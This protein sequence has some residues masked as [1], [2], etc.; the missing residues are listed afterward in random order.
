MS[1]LY[2]QIIVDV[3]TMQTNQPYT[4]LVPTDMQPSLSV[5]MRVVVPFGTRKVLGFVIAL[6]TKAPQTVQTLKSIDAMMDLNPILSKEHLALSEYLAQQTFAYR[7]AI[8]QT[9]LPNALKADYQK[10]L[11][12][13][14]DKL[15]PEVRERL[16]GTADNV[17]FNPSDWSTADQA[18][19]A[20]LQRQGKV[21]IDIHVHDKA[22]IKT[23]LAYTLSSD[24]EMLLM[25][26]EALRA[27]AQ[28]Q[29]ALL[30][31]VQAHLGETWTKKELQAQLNLSDA[32]LQQGVQKGWLVK[33]QVEQLR[34]PDMQATAKRVYALNEEQQVAFETIM[35]KSG[36][37]QPFLLSGITGSGKTEV[38]LQVA[39]QVLAQGKNILFLVPEIA[40]TPQMVARV[41]QRF[42]DQIAVLHSGLSEGE[43]YDEWRRI[44]RSAARVVVG[45]RSAV[46]A[47][48]ANIGL[49]IVD[50]EHETTYKQSDNPRYHARD[51][52]LWRGK[53]H[54]APVILGS[55]TPSLESRARAQ[56]GVYTLLRLT[57]R[58]GQA[59]L[60]N[61][62]II[63]M[64]D[65][66]VQGP[67]TDI[68]PQL[69]TQIQSRLN[70]GEQSVLLLNRRGFSS[71]VMCR[72]C[73]FVPR[74]PNCNLAMT[75]H[76]DSHSLKCHY[77][78]HEEAI[79][80]VCASCGS[81]EIRY[82]GTG[83]EKVESELKELFPEAR[84]L[85][86]DQDTTRKKGS[87]AT[88]LAAFGNQEYDILLGTQMIAKGLDFPDVTL[89]GVLNADTGLGLP[90]FHASERTFQ[91]LTQVAG[92]AGRAHK[93][94]EVWIQT[95]N[96]DHYAIQLAQQ[97]DYEQFY[98]YEMRQRHI[99]QYAPYYFTVQIQ[100]SHVEE[101]Q[102]AVQM[103]KAAKWLRERLPN[104]AILLGPTPK[105]I[106]K[107]RNRY[108][109]QMILK[110]KNAQ[111]I[112][113]LLQVLQERAQVIAKK[114]LQLSI[115]RE[116]VNFL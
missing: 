28:K 82:Y 63:D 62:Q 46:F 104:D 41:A 113:P 89:V 74:D 91:L 57:Q 67:E 83:T 51:V 90:D 92:R 13:R 36:Q 8:L 86:L 109:Y 87:M 6:T 43:R 94:G 114:G 11:H 25:A 60:P 76:M 55:A 52:A 4:Y 95:F 116:P 61:V 71:F 72:D 53:H 32:V 40:L 65:V 98:Q 99:G 81:R 103:A 54:Q 9:M 50:E 15:T 97:Q 77:C 22:K 59:A 79:P 49:I 16:F 12:L 93:A 19:I 26:Q 42:G 115:D 112:D 17:P 39:E 75:L 101:N 20:K 34:R 96:P 27:T 78:G 45:A 48:L 105:P 47:P 21:T 35:A 66:L 64:K 30:A 3:P 10:T 23:Q 33:T 24:Q 85:R 102:A 1:E 44:E 107:M 68:A 80:S 2:A 100:A 73:G 31:F 88:K 69:R 38:Y 70:R 37:Y 110:Y 111:N 58:A 14:D 7:I 56:R 5:G 106:A 84:V 29:A 18:L 108:Y